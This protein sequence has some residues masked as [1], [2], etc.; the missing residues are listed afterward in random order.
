MVEPYLHSPI[1][2]HII[3]LTQLSTGTT[4]PLFNQNWNVLKN[5]NETPHFQIGR[6]SLI[7]SEVIAFGQTDLSRAPGEI[8]QHLYGIAP[9]TD[10]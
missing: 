10:N 7:N 2:L 3:I 4:L 6:K 5:I 9:K 8:L 1:H